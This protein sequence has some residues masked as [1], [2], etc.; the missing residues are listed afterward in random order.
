[1]SNLSIVLC[2]YDRMFINMAGLQGVEA[3]ASLAMVMSAFNP[4][5]LGPEVDGSL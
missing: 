4:C 1:M 3:H 2:T 5:R